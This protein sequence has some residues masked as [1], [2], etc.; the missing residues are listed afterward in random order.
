MCT[1]AGLRACVHVLS[2]TWG[3]AHIHVSTCCQEPHSAP[4]SPHSQT[5]EVAPRGTRWSSP[6]N[7]EAQGEEQAGLLPSPSSPPHTAAEA[8][9]GHGLDL[10]LWT[11]LTLA[12]DLNIWQQA[13]KGCSGNSLCCCQ[14]PRPLH[15]PARGLGVHIPSISSSWPWPSLFSP[16]LPQSPSPPFLLSL[17]LNCSHSFCLSL[18]LLPLSH[19]LSPP[20]L[21][22][23]FPLSLFLTISGS[24]MLSVGLS[25]LIFCL[26]SP[27]VLSLSFYTVPQ[28]QPDSLTFS[29]PFQFLGL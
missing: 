27:W 1:R 15:C 17:F 7:Q 28:P 24:V 12:S 18:S 29:S 25:S 5:G 26:I 19:S 2:R 8:P 14:Q 22:L 23:S 13:D 21:P 11:S 10:A 3:L 16:S 20:P 4:T 6:E 9:A